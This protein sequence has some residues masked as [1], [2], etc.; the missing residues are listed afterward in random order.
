MTRF[1]NDTGDVAVR[2]KTAPLPKLDQ[3]GDR[4]AGAVNAGKSRKMEKPRMVR[5][6]IRCHLPL[7]SAK[8]LI[9]PL[10]QKRKSKMGHRLLKPVLVLKPC[11]ETAH[12]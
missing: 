7:T 6:Q 5:F 3:E 4:N 2:K 11:I 12:E 9:K 10:K 8:I 1:D